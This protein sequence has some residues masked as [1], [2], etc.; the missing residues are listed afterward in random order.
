MDA[1]VRISRIVWY[2][3]S[4]NLRVKISNSLGEATKNLSPA[5]AAAKNKPLT[6]SEMDKEV[7]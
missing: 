6:K 1:L 7:S 2:E 4:S 3:V 5:E